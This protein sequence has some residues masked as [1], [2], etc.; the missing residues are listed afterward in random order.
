M[1]PL[2]AGSKVTGDVRPPR[3]GVDRRRLR[4]WLWVIV[5]AIWA[6]GGIRMFL[7]HITYDPFTDS[8]VYYDAAARLNEGLPLYAPGARIY[9]P[10]FSILWRPLALMPFE[11]AAAIWEAILLAALGLT[12]WRLG[13]R[14]PATWWAALV[15]SIGIAWTLAI[16]QAEG[17]VTVLLAFGNPLTVALAANIKLYPVLIGIYWLARR[18]W[19]RLG[20]FACC[21]GGLVLLQLVLDPSDTFAF[22]GTLGPSEAMS[23]IASV[24]NISPFAISPVLW[25]IFGVVGFGL[26]LLLAPTRW[27]WA[28]VVAFAVLIPPRLFTFNM[29]SLLACLGGPEKVS[30]DPRTR[31]GEAARPSRSIAGDGQV[32]GKETAT[33]TEADGV[34]HQL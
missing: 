34:P 4:S 6:L 8:R 13:I 17:L 12:L 9:P 11:L 27:A 31:Q 25:V 24:G 16:G 32:L 26:V 1:E 2:G 15:L 21:A 30:L 18:D 5:A 33:A 22:P 3:G 23:E 10:L 19:R 7:F 28:A 29:T 14:R 20:L